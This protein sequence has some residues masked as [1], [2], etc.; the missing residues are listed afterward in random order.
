MGNNKSWFLKRWLKSAINWLDNKMFT[1]T[2]EC[3]SLASPFWWC[4]IVGFI[5]CIAIVFT[6]D[7]DTA[8]EIAGGIIGA[9]LLIILIVYHWKTLRYFP[10]TGTKI[11]R[12]LLSLVLAVIGMFVGGLCAML[13]LLVLFLYLAW[14][15]IDIFLFNGGSSSSSS[16][17]F[18]SIKTRHCRH[19][20]HYNGAQCD[21]HGGGSIIDPDTNAC[22]D[23]N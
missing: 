14:K 12:V 22:L 10:R 4:V 17:S 1:P 6:Q 11:A 15:I 16:S 18:E 7:S 9:C 20:C 5:G 8:T 21:L 23:F 19:C 3:A 2:Q 13:V